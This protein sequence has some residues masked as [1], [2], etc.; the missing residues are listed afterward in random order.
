MRAEAW[1][2]LFQ[3]EDLAGNAI[4][5]DSMP[6][7]TAFVRREPA[8]GVIRILGLD[9]VRRTI[10]VTGLPLFAHPGDFVGVVAVFWELAGRDDAG[11]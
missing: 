7:G 1:A 2:S 10:S 5:L 4:S 8:H 6:A 11:P 9:R 3:V